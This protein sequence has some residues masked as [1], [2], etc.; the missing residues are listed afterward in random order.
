MSKRIYTLGLLTLTLTAGLTLCSPAYAQLSGVTGSV[1]GTV[2]STIGTSTDI[3]ARTRT[4]ARVKTPES[5]SK[6]KLRAN[7]PVVV[8]YGTTRSGG[9]HTH[10]YY[11]R[12]THTH[13]YNHFH[14][15]HTHSH[16]H[17]NHVHL[18]G[19][20][21]SGDKQKE[22]KKDEKQAGLKVV[23]TKADLLAYGT[24]V[25]TEN[26]GAM[27][28]INSLQRVQDGQI[29][30]VTVGDAMTLIPV[31]ELYVDGNVLIHTPPKIKTKSDLAIEAQIEMI[32]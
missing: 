32:K 2:D 20:F 18:H 28:A 7:S 23:Y 27:G 10:G 30:G 25:R 3:S 5:R 13:G 1:G 31:G 26:G 9:Y 16:S 19:E 15:D 17:G 21:K 6:V 11:E 29:I 8:T 12:H 22:T 14:D 4:R 24:P